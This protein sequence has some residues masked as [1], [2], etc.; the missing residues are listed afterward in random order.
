MKP[1]GRSAS[2]AEWMIAMVA[3]ALI[4][5]LIRLVFLGMPP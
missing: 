5:A 2:L 1:G 3:V 4:L